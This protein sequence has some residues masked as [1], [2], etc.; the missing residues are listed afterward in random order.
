MA[1]SD[2]LLLIFEFT[3]PYRKQKKKF[4]I[5]FQIKIAGYVD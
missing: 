5:P 1:V 4:V 3:Q 2:I